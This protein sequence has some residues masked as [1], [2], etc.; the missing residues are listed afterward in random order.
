MD[1]CIKKFDIPKNIIIATCSDYI[2]VRKKIEKNKNETKHIKKDIERV[3]I[4]ILFLFLNLLPVLDIKRDGADFLT[5]TK[6]NI[7]RNN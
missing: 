3:I 5:L 2:S 6:D 7:L 4:R 1:V